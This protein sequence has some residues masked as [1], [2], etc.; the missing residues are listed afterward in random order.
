MGG[1]KKIF[2]F[3]ETPFFLDWLFFWENSGRKNAPTILGLVS[4]MP[5]AKFSI[6][7]RNPVQGG[8]WVFPLE[9]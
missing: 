5:I 4:G 6:G 2:I 3:P 8:K 1:K 9:L 7:K